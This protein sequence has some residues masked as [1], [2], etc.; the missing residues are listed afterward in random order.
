LLRPR[1]VSS[2]TLLLLVTGFIRMTP[3][4]RKM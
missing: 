3:G 4:G 2:G 1:C